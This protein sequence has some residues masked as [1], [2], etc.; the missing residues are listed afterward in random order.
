MMSV[1]GLW[2]FLAEEDG[3]AI[4]TAT[5]TLL[6]NLTYRCAP[7]AVL[8]AVVVIPQM[9]RRG[10]ASSLLERTIVE[11]RAHGVDKVQLL[12]HKRHA[13]DGAHALY[14]RAGFIAEA[15]GFRRYL[16]T[17]DVDRGG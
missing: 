14:L 12:S 10:V 15:E 3:C 6:P 7:S 1:A 2:V 8:E 17:P 4:G 11:A 5:L 9:R 16:L 13:S